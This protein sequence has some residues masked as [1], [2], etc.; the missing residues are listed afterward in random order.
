MIPHVAQMFAEAQGYTDWIIGGTKLC[1]PPV[2][3]AFRVLAAI[4]HV[5]D[6]LDIVVWQKG[7]L[8]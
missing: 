6:G 5:G 3:I 1:L 8:V 7:R 2:T 4:K